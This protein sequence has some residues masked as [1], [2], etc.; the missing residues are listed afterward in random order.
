MSSLTPT[1]EITVEQAEEALDFIEANCDGISSAINS[2]I[3]RSENTL[4]AFIQQSTTARTLL[5]EAGECLKPFA[6]VGVIVDGPFGPALFKEDE[7]AFTSGCAW[8]ENG[9]TKTLKWGQ[10]RKA[11]DLARRIREMGF[12][13]DA[14]RKNTSADSLQSS[15]GEVL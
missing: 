7:D 5:A 15:N 8:T 9:E 14:G 12:G 4:R 10:F 6:T 1:P 13:E 11:A 2:E 3:V